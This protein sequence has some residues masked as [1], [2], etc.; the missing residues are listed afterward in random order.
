M[1]RKYPKDVNHGPSLLKES[2]GFIPCHT[3]WFCDKHLAAGPDLQY[4]PMTPT[5]AYLR[6]QVRLQSALTSTRLTETPPSSPQPKAAQSYQ[7]RTT[8]GRNLAIRLTFSGILAKKQ[9]RL[10]ATESEWS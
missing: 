1:Y 5:L 4:L 7:A 6:L 8:T 2:D 9:R 10:S 3:Q